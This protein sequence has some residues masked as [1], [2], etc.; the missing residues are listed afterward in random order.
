MR[1]KKLLVKESS[2]HLKFLM[3]IPKNHRRASYL[4]N[5]LFLMILQ[6]P[7]LLKKKPHRQKNLAYLVM[8]RSQVTLLLSWVFPLEKKLR[9]IPSN[10]SRTNLQKIRIHLK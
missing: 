7:Y 10:S 4:R 6:V 8:K 2:R 3:E 9:I 1:K 5:L